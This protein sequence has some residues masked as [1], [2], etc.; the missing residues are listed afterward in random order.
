MRALTTLLAL[1][2]ALAVPALAQT[3]QERAGIVNFTQVDAVVACGGA[4]ETS[5]LDGLRKD[6][7]KTVINLRL[8]TEQGANIEQNTA[9]AKELGLN[10]ISIPFNAQAPDTKAVDTFLGVIANKANQPVYIHCGSASR[11]GG[12]WMIKR[13]LQDGWALDKATEEAKL[14]GL[15]NPGLEKFAVEYINSHKK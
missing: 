4:T 8:P 7:F 5:A 15:R 3:K 11:V 14:I 13:V 12:M 10:Y 1:A 2:L 6:G 9:Y